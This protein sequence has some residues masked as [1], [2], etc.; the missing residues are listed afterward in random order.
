MLG[1][2]LMLKSYLVQRNYELVQLND[3]MTQRCNALAS[4]L[5]DRTDEIAVLDGEIR[6]CA[7]RIQ[8]LEGEISRLEKEVKR[9]ERRKAFWRT[10]AAVEGGALIVLK[11][12]LLIL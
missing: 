5:D 11:V 6:L 1:E 9:Q 2:K 8:S 4:A 7:Q 12:A 3:L 10:V